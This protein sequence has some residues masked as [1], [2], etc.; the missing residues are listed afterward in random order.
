[1]TTT[2]LQLVRI[3]KNAG[4]DPAGIT[5]AVWSA[6]YRKIDFTTEQIIDIAVNMTGDCIYLKMPLETLPK[7]LDDISK[8]HLNGVI[9]EAQWDGSP[10]MIA[11]EILMNGYRN[12]R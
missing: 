3:I 4:G 10:A 2:D 5:E 11:M 12:E 7:T 8:C 6:G 1:M 9:D